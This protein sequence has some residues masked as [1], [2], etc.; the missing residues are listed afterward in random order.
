MR[1]KTVKKILKIAGICLLSLVLAV[2]IAIGILWHNEISAVLSIKMLVDTHEEN[3]S[4]PVY[5]MD[6]KGGYYFDEF[7]G[8]G[9]ASN[10]LTNKTVTWISNEEFH[11]PDAVFTFDFS[12]L[13]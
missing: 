6:I 3:R 7:I 12:Y 2:G 8:Q 10:D 5:M 13:N 11:N 9:G 4:A 1:K